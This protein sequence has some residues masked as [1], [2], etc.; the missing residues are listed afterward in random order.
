MKK[1]VFLHL[2]YK[3]WIIISHL[4]RLIMQN[5]PILDNELWVTH[6]A[7]FIYSQPACIPDFP[8]DACPRSTRLYSFWKDAL[9]TWTSNFGVSFLTLIGFEPLNELEL[10]WRKSKSDF[11]CRSFP[12]INLPGRAVWF[13]AILHRC[14]DILREH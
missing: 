13:W 12:F 5:F 11:A 10:E 2:Y 6:H 14:V 8:T 1:C 9:P 3:P 7:R 4:Y